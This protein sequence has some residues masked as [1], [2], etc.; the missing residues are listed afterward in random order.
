M[1]QGI[2]YG[3][4]TTKNKKVFI[5]GISEF[6]EFGGEVTLNLTE[7]SIQQIVSMLQKNNTSGDTHKDS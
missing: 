2:V 1:K 7:D 3:Q 5:Q 6:V 4:K